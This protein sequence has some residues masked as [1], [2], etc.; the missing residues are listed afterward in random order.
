MVNIPPATVIAIAIG[1]AAPDRAIFPRDAVSEAGTGPCWARCVPIIAVNPGAGT[2]TP[3]RF[4]DRRIRS[5]PLAT[6][7]VIVWRDTPVALATAAC[8]SPFRKW[9]HDR[10]S[11]IVGKFSNGL[12]H[13][14]AGYRPMS[15]YG[16]WPPHPAKCVSRI[17]RRP[18]D[19][20]CC[21]H[22]LVAIP[23]NHAPTESVRGA[24]LAPASRFKALLGRV[25]GIR[26]IS[27][28]GAGTWRTPSAHAGK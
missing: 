18:S 23:C 27:E 8:D 6:R 20:M 9:R 26:R 13:Q 3:R 25:L 2:S 12:V 19:R 4:S 21:R 24:L 10:L 5:M 1:F 17:L 7:Y 15:P 14:G 16:A 22:R 28:D 11:E